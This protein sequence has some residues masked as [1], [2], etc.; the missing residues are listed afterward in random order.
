M[1]STCRSVTS[2]FLR[3]ISERQIECFKTAMQVGYL[4]A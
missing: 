2:R 4:L 3:S 1:I